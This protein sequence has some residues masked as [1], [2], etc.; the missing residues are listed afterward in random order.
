MASLK[1]VTAPRSKVAVRV[2]TKSIM[3]DHIG[4]S[5]YF[6][7]EIDETLLADIVNLIDM[8]YL[9]GQRDK[10]NEIKQALTVGN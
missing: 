7:Q 5:I 4:K 6:K 2:Y 10:A 3:V 9:K 1:E 8:A